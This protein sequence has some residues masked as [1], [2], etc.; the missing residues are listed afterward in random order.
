MSTVLGITIFSGRNGQGPITGAPNVDAGN[1]LGSLMVLGPPAA[2]Q[3][4]L[5]VVTSGQAAAALFSSYVVENGEII[6]LATTDLSQNIVI[7]TV[8]EGTAPA[9]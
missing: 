5:A 3:A 6:Q 9:G 7:A 1:R 8:L 4:G 2:G